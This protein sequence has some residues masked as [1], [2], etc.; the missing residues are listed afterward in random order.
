MS[1]LLGAPRC[2]PAPILAAPMAT[3]DPPHIRA[4]R[5]RPVNSPDGAREMV[6]HVAPQCGVG[7]ELGRLWAPRTPIGIPLGRCGSV[8][9]GAAAGRGVPSQ[10]SGDR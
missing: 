3:T 9:Q 2:R 7:S 6:L 4:S 1:D 5:T 10:F 8:L